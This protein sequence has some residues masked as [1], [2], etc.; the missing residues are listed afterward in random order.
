MSKSIRLS[1]TK[2]DEIAD[3]VI[4][5]RYADTIRSLQ[6]RYTRLGEWIWEAVVLEPLGGATYQLEEIRRATPYEMFRMSNELSC[7]M[8]VP[9]I[10]SD[11]KQVNMIARLPLERTKPIPVEVL[12]FNY[13]HDTKYTFAEIY[14]ELAREEKG[15]RERRQQEWKHVRM[16]LETFSTVKRLVEDWPEIQPFLPKWATQ[17]P[18][19]HNLPQQE[20]DT[21]RRLTREVA[22]K[23]QG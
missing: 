3:R 2:R 17:E 9:G 8:T 15:H 16:A 18:Q 1:G 4:D 11:A 13:W 21:V 10:Q 23:T 22:P 6:N 14:Y 20:L 12:E 5:A 7:K 19:T